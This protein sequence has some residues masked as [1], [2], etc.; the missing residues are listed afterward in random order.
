MGMARSVFGKGQLDQYAGH[1]KGAEQQIGLKEEGERNRWQG[2]LDSR[3][4]R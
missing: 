1:S 2:A 4:W 3:L